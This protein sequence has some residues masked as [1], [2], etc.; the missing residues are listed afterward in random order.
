MRLLALVA[1]ARV[2]GGRPSSGPR[3]IK[4]LSGSLADLSDIE[5]GPDFES[6]LA[7][8]LFRFEFRFQGTERAGF[9]FEPEGWTAGRFAYA[10]L[11]HNITGRV[12]AFLRG[13]FCWCK[14][15]CF[16]HFGFGNL[17]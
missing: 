8:G 3:K 2:V 4:V 17:L 5:N 9:V 1:L 7:H 13:R 10:Q 12:L 6:F 11:H 15:Q 16:A 14:A